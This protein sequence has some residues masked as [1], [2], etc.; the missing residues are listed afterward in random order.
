[1][2]ILRITT[3]EELNSFMSRYK[4]DYGSHFYVIRLREGGSLT[5][6]YKLFPFSTKESVK[7]IDLATMVFTLDVR[8]SKE[9]TKVNVVIGIN[10]SDKSLLEHDA[11]TSDVLVWFHTTDKVLLVNIKDTEVFDT[12]IRYGVYLAV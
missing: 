9:P 2:E 10:N 7:V 5:I 3:V 11:E 8:K 4:L 12:V 1:M 6:E